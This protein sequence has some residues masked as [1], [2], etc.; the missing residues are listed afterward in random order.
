[1]P[2]RERGVG[3]FIGQSDIQH[4]AGFAAYAVGKAVQFIILGKPINALLNE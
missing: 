3:K 4:C 1:M 2:S